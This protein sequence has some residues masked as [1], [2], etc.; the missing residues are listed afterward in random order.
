[1]KKLFIVATLFLGACSTNSNPTPAGPNTPNIPGIKPGSANI[2]FKGTS[3][4][5]DEMSNVITFTLSDLSNIEMAFMETDQISISVRGER[6]GNIVGTY[7]QDSTGS[8]LTGG[9]ISY[10]EGNVHYAVIPEKS[11]VEI[12]KLTSNVVEG[13]I[14]ITV[15]DPVTQAEYPV[16]GTFKKDR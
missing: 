4:T 7:F 15:E 13:T 10:E 14:N 8:N 3:Y 2:T 12:T 9:I 5:L 1:M 11:T 16:T 6:K